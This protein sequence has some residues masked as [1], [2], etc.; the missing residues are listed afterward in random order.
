[1]VIDFL[2]LL[3]IL[4]VILGI[5][6]WLLGWQ[7]AYDVL[8]LDR[9]PYDPKVKYAGVG[10]LLWLTGWLAVPSFIGALAGEAV[11]NVMERR[12]T[13]STPA[14]A[15]RKLSEEEDLPRPPPSAGSGPGVGP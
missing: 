1:M 14:Q 10:W 7:V 3:A 12:S 2:P 8:V 11:G 5:G 15:A 6:G 13:G 9:P 4:A